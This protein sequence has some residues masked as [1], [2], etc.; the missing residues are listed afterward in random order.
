MCII[1]IVVPIS[2]LLRRAPFRGSLPL[3]GSSPPE[4]S[5][6][7]VVKALRTHASH[8]VEVRMRLASSSPIWYG[9][10]KTSRKKDVGAYEVR[11]KDW[12]SLRD[13]PSHGWTHAR[14][15]GMTIYMVRFVLALTSHSR[16]LILTHLTSVM[17][18]GR[19]TTAIPHY[20]RYRAVRRGASFDRNRYRRGTTPP[21]RPKC[22]PPSSLPR[23]TRRCS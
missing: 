18:P 20:R 16:Y 12:S 14:W 21:L 9:T 17:S 10:G 2:Y 1:F 19:Y 4:P 3:V 23:Q 6:T 15:G 11:R 22:H 8:A 13:R 5:E 7:E